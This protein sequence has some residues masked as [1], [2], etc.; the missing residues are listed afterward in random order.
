VLFITRKW[1]PAVGGMETYSAELAAA[2]AP[3]LQ[4]EVAALPGRPD[5]QPPGAVALLGF[6]LRQGW[7][8]LT[9]GG[10]L[11]AVHGGDMAIWPLVALSRLGGRPAPLLSAHGTDVGFAFRPGF[12]PALY[13]AYMRL[14]ARL[15]GRPRV[16]ANSEATARHAR[17]LGFGRIA[18]VPLGCRVAEAP[19]AQATA[20]GLAPGRF[21]LFA[22]RLVRRKGLGWFVREVLP[23]LPGGL[24]LAVAGTVWDRSEAEALAA[25]GVRWLGPLAPEALHGLMAE[26]LCVVVPNVAAGR[27]HFEGFGLVAAEAAAA[28]GRVL[29]ARIDGFTDSVID[30]VTGTLLPPGDAPAWRAAIDALAAE[31]PEV[32]RAAAQSARAAARREFS[33]ERVAADTAALYRPGPDSDVSEGPRSR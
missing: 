20:H 31:A 27:G 16:I 25:P 17:A 15:A 5:G 2:L 13:R 14:G 30:G 22:G 32:R 33:W 3:R 1:P 24:E 7:R 12:R 19:P 6:G 9:R 11:D 21:V 10:A 28:G 26:A 29:A 8:V 4:L 18:V 23:G